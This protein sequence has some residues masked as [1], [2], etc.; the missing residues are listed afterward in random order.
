MDII[1]SIIIAIIAAIIKYMCSDTS[2]PAKQ[3]AAL[4]GAAAVG[5]VAGG[6]S[7]AT[8]LSGS[9][10]DQFSTGAASPK[11]TGTGVPVTNADGTIKTTYTNGYTLTDTSGKVTSY[12]TDGTVIPDATT[13]TATTSTATTASTSPNGSSSWWSSLGAAG[14]TALAAGGTALAAATIPTWIWLAA[15]GLALYMI[16]KD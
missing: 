2:T 14:T 6:L 4:A 13:T 15:G 7:Y 3:T 11:L 12:N 5:A 10:A 9:I 8:G 16:L 1:V